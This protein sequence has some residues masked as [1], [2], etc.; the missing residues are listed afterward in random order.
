MSIADANNQIVNFAKNAKTGTGLATVLKNYNFHP[1][2]VKT[3]YDP[4]CKK[5]AQSGTVLNERAENIIYKEMVAANTLLDWIDH[6]SEIPS[7]QKDPL[8]D[9]V[10]AL[11]DS[12]QA[13]TKRGATLRDVRKWRNSAK[14]FID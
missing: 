2:Y 10:W 5:P 7:A 3:I 12:L 11:L 6:D 1:D 8:Y 4:K 14:P 13:V 9:K